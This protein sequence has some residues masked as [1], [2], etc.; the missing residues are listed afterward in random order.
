[1]SIHPDS[2]IAPRGV[3]G[4]LGVTPVYQAATGCSP[5]TLGCVRARL[6]AIGSVL[7]VALA[8]STG[9]IASVVPP[10]FTESTVVTGLNQPTAIAFLPDGRMLVAEKEGALKSVHGAEVSTLTTLSVCTDKSMGL[11]GL[12]VDPEFKANGFVYA[13][14]TRPPPSGDCSTAQGR[15]NEVVRITLSG[16][17]VVPGSAHAI[18][19]GIRTDNG[20]HNG[21]TLRI[22]VDGKLYVSTGDTGLGDF[23]HPPDSNP[24]AQD[25][26]ELPG[27][28]LRLNLDGSVPLD[29]PFAGQPPKRPEIFAYG[30]RNPFRFGID[31][32][33]GN[34]W[35]GDVGQSAW[36]ELDVI[37][38]GGNYGWPLCEGPDPPGCSPPGY[39]PPIYAYPRTGP[40][41]SITGGA[42][43]PC[44]FGP[45]GGEYFFGD[46]VVDRLYRATP[47]AARDDVVTPVAG[48]VDAADG[49]V[50]IVF[51]PGGALYFVAIKAG[52][53]RRVAAT[54]RF[55]RSPSAGAGPSP[56]VESPPPAVT[57]DRVA[58]NPHLRFRSR[59]RLERVAI[60]VEP[61]EHATLT[62]TARIATGTAARTYRF[63]R[64]H[65]TVPAGK[66]TTIRLRLRRRA[67]GVL[68]RALRAHALVV[69]FAV[70]AADAAGNSRIERGKI[71][72]VRQARNRV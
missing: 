4:E 52:E 12:A 3:G 36:E 57:A 8:S 37:R 54:D 29:N 30:F 33:T 60:S 16:G 18:F 23:Q 58:P 62:V 39:V 59:Q 46:Y 20:Q 42:F 25:L 22:G 13:Y 44:D 56:A 28:V 34:L 70:T 65:R 31:P 14:R 21:G 40:G 66:R 27:K 9:A 10:G 45:Y 11:L 63:V 7:A 47:N 32:A 2:V 5:G 67:L 49:P 1:V 69:R 6:T 24:F 26:S 19:S 61:D 53:V 15:V 35:L 68:H 64:V 50:D 17:T 71:R 72:L 43:A 48:F 41:T 55:C 38:P 51:G